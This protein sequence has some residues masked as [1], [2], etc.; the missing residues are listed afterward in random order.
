MQFGG[1]RCVRA[2]TAKQSDRYN[3]F[4]RVMQMKSELRNITVAA[5]TATSILLI[6]LPTLAHHPFA[7]EFDWKKPVTLAGTVTKVNWTMPHATIA[8][9]VRDE[10]KV[11]TAWVVEL[12]SPRVLEKKYQWT[13]NVVK[14]GDTIIVDGWLTK[15]GRK[16]VSAK[17]VTLSDGRELFAASSFFDLPDQCISDEVCVEDAPSSFS[18]VK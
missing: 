17:S 16:F 6:G 2:D 15:D 12:G 10:A 9:D 7:V 4:K 18:N 1:R 3:V 13:T 11:V 5:M 14:I 8:I